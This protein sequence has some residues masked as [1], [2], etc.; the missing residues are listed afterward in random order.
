MKGYIGKILFIRLDKKELREE[1]FG[2]E[3]ARKYIGGKGFGAFYLNKLVNNDVD[4]L[5][6]DNPLILANGPLNGTRV[7]LTSKAG[8]FFKSPLTGGYGESIVGGSLPKYPKWVGYDAIIILGKADKP[9]ILIVTDDGVDF[10]DSRDL[11]GRDI[12][13]VDNELRKEF[14]KKSTIVAIGPAGE[15]LV[16]FAVIGVDKW[17]Q[18][19]RT[20]GGAVM[21][22]K[23]LKAI[24]FTSDDNWVSEANPN[25]LNELISDIVRK[26]K[27]TSGVKTL[28]TYGTSA[29]AT[30]ANEMGFF[31]SYYWST[32]H[33]EAWENISAESIKSVLKKSY[34]CWNCFIACGRYVSIDTNYG[35]VEI[36]G[37]EYETI[38]ALGGLIGVKDLRDLVYLNYLADIYGLDTITLGNVLGF[39]VEASKRG[40]I[41]F[42]VDYN[43]TEKFIEII[44][45]IT[46]RQGIGDI[47]AEGVAKA[48]SK[49]GLEEL[50]IHV[51]GLEP[52]GYDPRTLKGMSI[53]YAISPRG[54]CHLRVMAYYVDIKGFAGPPEELS[55]RKILKLIEFED[56]MTAFDSLMLCK[57]GRDIFKLDIM[58]RLYNAVTGFN[59]KYDEFRKSLER[60]TLL[61]R[62]FNE[63]HGFL[64]QNDYLSERLFSESFMHKGTERKLTRNEFER[65][66]NLYYKHRGIDNSG[67]IT[68]Q[69]KREL[70]I[71]RL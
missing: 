61:T 37:P 47:L 35:H 36:D 42:K 4:A 24:V 56:F 62:L 14:G 50:A 1:P 18:A 13:Y 65:A 45:M 11:W 20:G 68:S 30:L 66:L 57:F 41:D 69:K 6:P 67:L 31:P 2:E 22:S 48:A 26:R 17:R 60:V 46:Y 71:D 16:K 34:A 52:A 28:H 5:D 58:W 9:T 32:G 63:K 10:I 8:F 33:F 7:P 49:L 39:A 25:E 29:M 38:Y 53:G 51:K 44:K 23:N 3:F 40:K 70:G 15:N 59:V 43:D 55:E 19:A 27:E 21:G 54:A 64:R 12:E